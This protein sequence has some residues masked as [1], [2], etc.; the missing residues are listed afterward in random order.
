MTIFIKHLPKDRLLHALW[1]FARHSSY[2]RF[3]SVPPAVL[4][5]TQAREDI[6]NMIANDREIFVTTYYDRSLYVDIT[7]DYLDEFN[8][9][10]YN[11]RGLAEKIINQLK[12]QELDAVLLTFEKFY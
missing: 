12:Q 4:T 11:G 2:I 9:D 7:G 5:L 3:S 10:I 6:N 1:M 8:Y